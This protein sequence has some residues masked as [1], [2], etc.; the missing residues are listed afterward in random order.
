LYIIKYT[1][2]R[3]PRT[4]DRVNYEENAL[5]SDSVV[6]IPE[7]SGNGLYGILFIAALNV[8]RSYHS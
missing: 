7:A 3:I 1:L 4:F 8:A 2:L 5:S 6:K